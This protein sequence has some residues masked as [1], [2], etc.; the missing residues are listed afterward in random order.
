MKGAKTSKGLEMVSVGSHDK[1]ISERNR[2]RKVGGVNINTV[3]F[4]GKR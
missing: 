2:E 3:R 4:V 1:D